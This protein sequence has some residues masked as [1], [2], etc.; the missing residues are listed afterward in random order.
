MVWVCF[1]V[2]ANPVAES[3]NYAIVMFAGVIT[4]ALGYY[5][6]HG[7]KVYEGPVVF[8]RQVGSAGGNF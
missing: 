2:E 7:K 4:I 3:M 6:V 1:P 5:H 8:V